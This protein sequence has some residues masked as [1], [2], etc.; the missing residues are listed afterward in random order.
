LC[1]VDIFGLVLVQ[2][3]Q[4]AGGDPVEV[5]DRLA[6]IKVRRGGI[7]G[8]PDIDWLISEIE[9]LRAQS[10]D[11]DRNI[12]DVVAAYDAG[13]DHA[14]EEK[15]KEPDELVREMFD[16]WVKRVSLAMKHESNEIRSTWPSGYG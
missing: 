4:G 10:P 16:C 12:Q 9:R 11:S 2:D 8:G 13:R 15:G 7:T 3:S 5:S 6:D 1:S 14:N